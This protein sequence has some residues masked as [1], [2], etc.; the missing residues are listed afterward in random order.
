MRELGTRNQGI[1][2]AEEQGLIINNIELNHRVPMN[3]D[4]TVNNTVGAFY[5]SKRSCQGKSRKSRTSGT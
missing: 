2:F 4:L 5:C 3:V 1:A